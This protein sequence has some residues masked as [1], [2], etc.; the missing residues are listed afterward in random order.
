V[1]RRVDLVAARRP[2]RPLPR[3]PAAQ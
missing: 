3:P 1:R 2:D